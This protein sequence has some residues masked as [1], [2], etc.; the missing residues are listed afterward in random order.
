MPFPL[1]KKSIQ[2]KQNKT[3]R[4]SVSVSLSAL[5]GLD[6][7]RPHHRAGCSA[8]LAPHYPPAN[9]PGVETEGQR[10]ARSSLSLFPPWELTHLE[11]ATKDVSFSHRLSICCST[12]GIASSCLLS[13]GHG[14]SACH[15]IPASYLNHITTLQIS[16]FCKH[17]TI[18]EHPSLSFPSAFMSSLM[19]HSFTQEQCL[20]Y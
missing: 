9:L 20:D 6:L 14:G 16:I 17:Q 4:G 1:V 7:N 8:L 18:L 12:N 2:P 10:K 19:H 5:S 11:L 3:P 15:S 13:F